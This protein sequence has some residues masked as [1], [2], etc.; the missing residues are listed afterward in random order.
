ME[1]ASPSPRHFGCL[2]AILLLIALLLAAILGSL[3]WFQR[4]LHAKPF[5]PVT[6]TAPE[7]AALDRKLER[8]E[9]ADPGEPRPAD[10]TPEPYR[11]DPERRRLVFSERELNAL[12]NRDTNLA[13]HVAIDLTD[14]LASLKILAPMDPDLPLVGGKT[15]R[16]TMGVTLAYSNEQPSV[17]L[18]GI[19]LG[20][21]PLPAAWWGD[22]KNKNLV[23]EFSGSNG[24]WSA[25]ARGIEFLDVRDG[26]LHVHLKE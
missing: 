3:W 4:T 24:F 23:S 8:M 10:A 22:I 18:R 16:L 26:A 21:V 20:G 7:Q 12:L 19:S 5:A 11:E 2:H 6:L 1:T 15:L 13:Q 9:K 14:H 25:F 17:T